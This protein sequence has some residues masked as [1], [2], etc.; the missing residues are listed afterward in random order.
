LSI[1]TGKLKLELIWLQICLVRIRLNDLFLFFIF[2]LCKGTVDMK[3]GSC[4]FPYYEI[5][6]A[7]VDPLV[8]IHCCLIYTQSQTLEKNFLEMM[9]KKE[10]CALRILGLPL[11]K[12]FLF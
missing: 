4:A 10:C 12:T 9:L 8:I 2:I 5:D 1:H 6:F 3:S 7:V 11:V